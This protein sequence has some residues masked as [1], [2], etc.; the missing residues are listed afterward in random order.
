MKKAFL[1][2]TVLMALLSALALSTSAATAI[3][4]VKVPYA[5][6]APTLDGV[7]S[8]GEWTGAKTTVNKDTATL[9][10]STAGTYDEKYFTVGFDCYYAWDEEYLYVAWEMKGA[11]MWYDYG[12]NYI[13]VYLDPGSQFLAFGEAQQDDAKGA[14]F[15]SV[16]AV[17]KDGSGAFGLQQLGVDNINYTPGDDNCGL[18]TSENGWI[19][20]SR[21][22]WDDMATSVI[23]KTGNANA[24][25]APEAGYVLRANYDLYHVDSTKGTVYKGFWTTSMEQESIATNV[26]NFSKYADISLVL[27]AEVQEEVPSDPETPGDDTNPE[28][29]MNVV[30]PVVICAVAAAACVVLTKKKH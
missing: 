12:G 2:L 29:G 10:L 6:T 13:R 28:T 20:E 7:L 11:D 15:R 25:V 8:D 27:Q 1:L 9:A 22:A 24:T 23:T 19:Y 17:K 21:I 4:E 30:A 3:G 5:T 16:A 18:T 14:M 26:W